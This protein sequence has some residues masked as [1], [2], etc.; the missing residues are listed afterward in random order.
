M[1][2]PHPFGMH[3]QDISH[4][5][6]LGEVQGDELPAGILAQVSE[7]RNDPGD[8]VDPYGHL[9]PVPSKPPV[10]GLLEGH[11]RFDGRIVELQAPHHGAAQ[12]GSDLLDRM[13]DLDLDLTGGDLI[14]WQAGFDPQEPSHGSPHSLGTVEIWPVREELHIGVILLQAFDVGADHG[15]P[16]QYEI[17]ILPHQFFQVVI[18]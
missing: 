8:V 3:F 1:A 2:V 10:E 4:R 11:Q 15:E 17:A 5:E 16:L 18:V 14:T 9:P 12:V 6:A 13:I 7:G